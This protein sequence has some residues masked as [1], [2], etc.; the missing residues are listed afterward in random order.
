MLPAARPSDAH[1]YAM[2]RMVQAGVV[3]VTWQQVLLEW[4]RD[5][6][7]KETYDAVTIAGEGAFR[8]LR[9]GH[10]LRLHPWFTAERNASS[11]A[12]G[13]ARTPPSKAVSHSGS[14]ICRSGLSLNAKVIPMKIYLLSLGAGLL[15]GVIYSLLNVRSPAP[16][17]VAL[18]GLLGILVGEQIVPL[19]KSMWAASLQPFHGFIR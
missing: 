12:S 14:R 2:D 9:H 5:W 3:P 19:A 17:V 1:K 7:R 16:P 13:S 4:Q 10:R 11:T 15:V 8:R 18:I 6:A